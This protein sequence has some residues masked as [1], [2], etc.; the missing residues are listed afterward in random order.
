[1][2]I[3]KHFILL[4]SSLYITGCATVGPLVLI[5]TPEP[6]ED[7]VVVCGWSKVPLLALHGGGQ[8]TD[9]DVYVVSS[10]E[11]VECG[12]GYGDSAKVKVMHPVYVKPEI[13]K[14]DG[15]S[16]Y[17][18]TKTKLDVLDE[19]KAKFEAGFWDKERHPGLVYANNLVRCGFPHQYF[20]YY[21]KAKNV[22]VNYFKE[23]YHQL[24]LQCQETTFPIRKKYLPGY[25]YYPNPKSLM[26]RYWESDEWSQYK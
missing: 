2:N 3:L 16:V 10:G 19:L 22:D 17:H 24:I 15:A 25:E 14:R 20:K 13:I 23:K 1:M 8:V 6:A 11:S 9:E 4:L 7:F 21:S 18:Y 5:E 26:D 12:L